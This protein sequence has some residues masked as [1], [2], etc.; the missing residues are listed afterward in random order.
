MLRGVDFERVEVEGTT[1][2]RRGIKAKSLRGLRITGHG[3]H[4]S[5]LLSAE[6]F[7]HSDHAILVCFVQ[8]ATVR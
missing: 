1:E 2:I 4:R 6:T 8:V 7:R 3:A 5:Q